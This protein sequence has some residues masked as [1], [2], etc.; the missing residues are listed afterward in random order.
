MKKC[1]QLHILVKCLLYWYIFIFFSTEILSYFHL[2][3][4]SYILLGEILFWAFFLLFHHKEILYYIQNICFRSKSLLFILFLFLLTF[5]Q[6]LF[7][8]P[9]STD[10]MVYH[11]PRVMYWVQEKSLF[12]DIVHN[13]HDYMPPFGQYI[14]LHLYLMFG[15]DRFL[16]FSQWIA[17]VVT[18]IISG[19]IAGYLGTNRQ[20]SKSI[21]LLIACL[22]VAV[23]QATNTKVE[24][25]V[26]G[27][28][29][30]C[31]YIALILRK[32]KIWDYIIL[33]FS[34]GLG[35]LTKQTFLLYAVIPAGILLIKLIR[36]KKRY[37]FYLLLIFIV[38]ITIQARFIFQNLLLY[39]NVSGSQS[40]YS[41]LT[42]QKI[43][44]SGISSNL[45]KNTMLHI[46]IPIYTK[47]AED[48]VI[49]LHK[50]LGIDVNDCVTTFCNPDFKFSVIR[51][52]FPQED[53]A[54]NTFHLILIIAAGF[55]LIK[56][57]MNRK[58]GFFE[59]YIYGLAMLSYV[60]FSALL[61]WQPFHSRL[62]MP[63]FVIGTIVSV[64]ILSK[65]KKGR[66]VISGIQY[67]SIPLVLILILFNV[68]KPYISYTI[69]YGYV[70]SFATPLSSI[71]E[72]FY[73]KN[74]TEQYFN[75]RYYWYYPYN[76][77]IK[78]LGDKKYI[79][80]TIAFDLMDGFEYPF[81][82]L[83]RKYQVNLYV[84][85]MSKISRNTIIISTSKD[86][87]NRKGYLTE[88][89]KTEIEYGYEC[90]SIKNG[91]ILDK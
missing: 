28:V 38:V 52:I 41:S 5:V 83:M 45:I 56:Q 75:A 39:E 55:M 68:L 78:K 25:I 1:L 43:S 9:N 35:L 69:I 34:F 48:I 15:N 58:I 19:K 44:L 77:I 60:A 32:D 66:Y 79:G 61:K 46:P 49:Y 73:I 72:A 26:T 47:Q 53:I 91:N 89:V 86:P 40:D 23:M 70:K 29:V 11:L 33:G 37:F 71:P 54:S 22:P 57:L 67:I 74:R 88:C 24:L 90:I 6:G 21:S 85:P 10:S 82:M 17:Y 2:I 4:K 63:F 64:L 8:A 51:A 87:S 30:I 62:H 80:N 14:L 36:N 20:V 3:E 31:T 7:S 76:E 81:W 27:L 84:L 12:Q 59:S 18:V 13:V 50:L 42:N 65:T 16:F